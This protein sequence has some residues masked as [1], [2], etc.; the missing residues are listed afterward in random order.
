MSTKTDE[1]M[2]SRLY[3]DPVSRHI[4]QHLSLGILFVNSGG[5]VA[6]ACGQFVEYV[7]GRPCQQLTGCIIDDLLNLHK[8]KFVN[9]NSAH[10]LKKIETTAAFSKSEGK[11]QRTESSKFLI[12]MEEPAH[13][14]EGPLWIKL[15]VLSHFDSDTETPVLLMI[16]DQSDQINATESASRNTKDQDQLIQKILVLHRMN[17]AQIE[18]FFQNFKG[19]MESVELNLVKEKPF[20]FYRTIHAIAGIA[21]SAN[22]KKLKNIAIQLE[23]WVTSPPLYQTKV[24]AK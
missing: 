22:L 3:P 20:H 23:T 24:Y 5:T 8:A 6:K 18:I 4:L 2:D 10:L 14:K 1:A 17:S 13:S 21:Q 12:K 19:L 11:K 16:E 7:F 9:E 15:T